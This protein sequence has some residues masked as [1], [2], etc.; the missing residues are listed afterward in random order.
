MADLATP[1]Q[2]E[3]EIRKHPDLVVRERTPYNGGPPPALQRAS[4]LTPNDLFFVR[5]HAPVPAVDPDSYR[6]TVDGAVE[7]PLSLSLADLAE[8]F[9]R[10]ELTATL[11]CAGQ[12]RQEMAAIAPLPGELPWD[13]DA[14]STARWSGWRLADLLTAAGV[15]QEQA[16]EGARAA[17][18][19]FVGLDDVERHGRTFGFG[20]S[21][22]LG[23]A[24]TPEVL[25]ADRMNGEPLPPTHGFPLRVVVPGYIGAR[26]VK[27]VTRITIQERSSDNYFQSVAY[28]LYPPGTTAETADPETAFELGELS[29]SSL[30][31][32]PAPGAEV[33]AGPVTVRGLAFA[34]GGRP[35]RRVDLSGDGGQSWIQARLTEDGRIEDPGRRG[36]AWR[37]FE[38]EVVLEPGEREIVARAWDTAGNTQPESPAQVWNYKGYMNN[39]WSRVRVR[40][41]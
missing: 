35:V 5:N 39:A 23:K 36:W 3:E 9:R 10:V 15:P 18:A 6:L 22:P 24:L 14:V 8:R 26:S 37:F 25:L 11:Q 41:V 1:P 20:G 27:W 7:R 17:H 4:F 40:C 32:C 12:R 34:G 21:I 28:R 13:A 2:I 31:A 16:P 30:I 19:A 38:G 29:V 33:A